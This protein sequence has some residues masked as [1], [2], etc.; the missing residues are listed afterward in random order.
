M[1]LWFPYLS[2]PLIGPPPPTLPPGTLVRWRPFVPI[3]VHSLTTGQDYDINEALVDS[4]ADDTIFPMDVATL[5][6]I[7]LLPLGS[8]GH[9]IRWGTSR[10]PIRFGEVR[11]ELS[12][13]IEAWNWNAIVAFTP[14]PIRYPLLGQASFFSFFDITFKG[15]AREVSLETNPSFPGTK[16]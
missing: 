5:T 13:G 6:G 8:I 10:H 4:G 1:S 11:L 16:T 9:S 14:A 12:D 7:A 2:V 3:R 15:E